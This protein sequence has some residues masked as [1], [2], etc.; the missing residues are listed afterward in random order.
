MRGRSIRAQTSMWIRFRRDKELVDLVFNS[1]MTNVYNLNNL[2]QIVL[3][4]I[5][6]IS[7]QIE[8]PLY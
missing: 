4:I 6:N 7:Y 3:E 2:N 8:N 5:N 1:L